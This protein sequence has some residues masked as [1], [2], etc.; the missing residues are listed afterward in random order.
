M[1]RKYRL[2]PEEA[3]RD[4]ERTFA[5]LA[6]DPTFRDFICMYIGEG[7]KRSRKTVSL[8]NSDP[9]VMALSSHWVRR[10][11]SSRVTYQLRHHAD[12]NVRTL[13][14][15]WAGRLGVQPAEIRPQRKSNSGRLSG[16]TWR[17]KYGVLSVTVHDTLFRAR[18]QAWM[19]GLQEQWLDSPG[20]GA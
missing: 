12:Q 17:S 14:F 7:F 13:C 4:G 9:R 18:L 10:L 8:G 15:F 19:D 6:T 2:P 1:Q 16:R 3:Y 20:I 5:A 11:T